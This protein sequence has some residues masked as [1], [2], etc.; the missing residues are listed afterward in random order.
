ME[1]TFDNIDYILSKIF[2]AEFC[3]FILILCNFNAE[4]FKNGDKESVITV[5]CRN[6]DTVEKYEVTVFNK[7]KSEYGYEGNYDIFKKSEYAFI[8]CDTEGICIAEL[9]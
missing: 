5:T 7:E 9:S 8:I 3:N 1:N 6:C 4:H 2:I